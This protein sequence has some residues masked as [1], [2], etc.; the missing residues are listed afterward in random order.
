MTVSTHLSPVALCLCYTCCWARALAMLVAV[1]PLVLS[2]SL[3]LSLYHSGNSEYPPVTC[4]SVSM[5]YLLLGQSI[6]HAGSCPTLGAVIISAVV[7]IPQITVSTHL[8]LVA[9]CLCCSVC[10][11]HVARPEQWLSWWESWSGLYCCC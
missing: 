4:S 10:A 3:L 1:L 11:V 2:S 8:S 6:G 9:L 5:L 7:I